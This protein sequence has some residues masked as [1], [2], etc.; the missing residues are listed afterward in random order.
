MKTSPRRSPPHPHPSLH[1]PSCL[2]SLPTSRTA[3]DPPPGRLVVAILPRYKFASARPNWLLPTAPLFG[4][5]VPS[6]PHH[7]ELPR[8]PP[9][10]CSEHAHGVA[11]TSPF[12]KSLQQLKLPRTDAAPCWIIMAARRTLYVWGRRQLKSH[13][14]AGSQT[15]LRAL[16]PLPW[17]VYDSCKA[18]ALSLPRPSSSRQAPW[19]G[20]YQLPST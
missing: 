1:T 11:V 13:G 9:S 5:P 12:A 3:V 2:M 7:H 16:E 20:L 8:H 10:A 17:V 15:V 14:P 18:L 6:A 4:W 19:F